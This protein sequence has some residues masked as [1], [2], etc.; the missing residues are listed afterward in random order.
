MLIGIR[1]GIGRNR[2]VPRLALGRA[3]GKDLG[4]LTLVG[5]VGV[6]F[7]ADADRG[8]EDFILSAEL[9]GIVPGL[10]VPAPA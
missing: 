4:A 5:N 1:P 7:I 9:E 6:D 10:D 8:E 2:P 3:L